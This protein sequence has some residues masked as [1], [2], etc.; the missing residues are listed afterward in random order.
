[1]KYLLRSIYLIICLL[2]TNML[3]AQQMSFETLTHD[4][5]TIA[6]DGG[7]VTYAFKFKSTGSSPVVI[8]TA[9]SSCG[10][11]TP[12]Y[13][14]QPI[15][16]GDSSTI[17]VTYDPMDRPGKFSKTVQVIMAPNNK[18][19]VLTITGDVTPRIKTTEELYP[20]DM[21][22]GLRFS[23]N[24]YPMSLIEQGERR[25][26]QVKYI[27]TSK[28]DITLKLFGEVKSGVIEIDF[29]Q[30]IPA[31][32]EGVATMVYD[33]KKYKGTYGPLADKFFV[34]I[35]NRMS[36]YRLMANAH[37]VDSFADDE[38]ERAASS[39]LSSRII[40]FAETK[41]GKVTAKQS[42]SIENTGVAPL[43]IRH[44]DLGEGVDA[45]L[46]AG[47]KIA[48]GETRKFTVWVDTRDI[49][50]GTYTRYITITSTDPDEPMQ[51]IRISGVVVE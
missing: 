40:K 25:E 4:F 7:T 26:V 20:F 47:E 31:G 44:A 48:A 12:V 19:Y 2:A 49:E 3:S 15:A 13:S 39:T 17:E 16:V 43:T 51:K 36:K 37:A 5:G 28:R 24:Y 35:N 34:N 38:R 6:E 33:L 27:N 18:K 29:P 8:V 9:V 11:T 1:M 50:Y 23:S 41:K 10:C 46:K 42:F 21:G 14:R 45:S 22:S 32:S 30:T